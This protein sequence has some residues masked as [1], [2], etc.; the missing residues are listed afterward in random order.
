MMDTPE[1]TSST[2]PAKTAR[3]EKTAKTK[4]PNRRTLRGRIR[5]TI[6]SAS[7][8][9]VMIYMALTL[10]FFAI[11]F[12]PVAGFASSFIGRNVV[13]QMNSRAFLLEHNIDRLEDFDPSTPSGRMWAEKMDRTADLQTYVP[14]HAQS[15]LEE[16]EERHPSRKK[17]PLDMDF[18]AFEVELNGSVIYSNKEKLEQWSRLDAGKL[19]DYYSIPS[20][21]PLINHQGEKVGSVKAMIAPQLV[22][23]IL[24]AVAGMF[25]LLVGITLF[26]THLISKLLSH[27]VLKPLEQLSSRIRAIAQEDYETTINTQIELAR[28]PR[29]IEELAD[30][31]NVIMQKMKEYNERLQSQKETVEEQNEELEAQNEELTESKRK[32]QEAQDRLIVRER[33][34]RNLM[35][36]AGQGFLTF[37]PD[38]LVDQEYSQEC[39]KIF[40]GP[41]GQVDIAGLLALHDPEQ[42]SFLDSLLRKIFSSGEDHRREMYIGLLTDALLIGDRHISVEY[43]M[44]TRSFENQPAMMVILTDITDKVHMENRIESERNTLK[45]VVKVIVEYGDFIDCVR[46]F[47]QFAE[48]DVREIL[49]GPED[50]GSKLLH[51]YRDIHTYKGNFSQFGLPHVTAHLHEAE[52]KLSEAMKLRSGGGEDDQALELARSFRFS[53]WLEEDFAVLHAVLGES[54]FRQQDLLLID[55]SRIVEI[56]KKMMALLAPNECKLL[57]PD[58]RKLR[59]KP[60]KELLKS[61]PDYVETLA[62]RMEKFVHPFTVEG[63]DFLADTE[64]YYDFSRSLIHVFRNIIDHAVEPAEE[65]LALGKDELGTIVCRIEK[66]GSHAILTV[67]DDGRGISPE[68]IRR[69]AAEKGIMTKEELERL[70]DREAVALVFRDEFSTKD[71]VTDISG[72]GIG[73]SAVKA[74]TEKLGG[75]VEIRSVPGQGTVFRFTLPYEDLSG[76]PETDFPAMLQPSVPVTKDYFRTHIGVELSGEEAYAGY[77]ADKLSLM[78][79][80]SFVSLKG[81]VEGAF[82]LSMDRELSRILVRHM[83]LEP[84]TPEEEERFLEDSLA[85]ASNIILGNSFTMF[86]S[87]ADYILMEPPITIRTEGASFKMADTDIWSCGLD[88]G[89][90]GLRLSF[91]LTKR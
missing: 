8:V 9:N 47:N 29:E 55:K 2:K 82:V 66:E 83:V 7:L 36:N 50:A 72:R 51:L 63:D 5:R 49:N 12:R 10:L 68:T 31:T 74:E 54:F 58:L 76:L 23:G 64:R 40:G 38:L 78:E 19:L 57:L 16:A 84:L 28:P 48:S 37:G 39:E 17:P 75:W 41:I 89:Y 71:E 30:S 79:V 61:Y 85:E 81:A 46:D 56:E 20:E 69:L 44:I 27:P 4:R 14:A 1:N 45:M 52:N 25:L 60:F 42:A 33:S 65:R 21:V 91:V 32:L 80:T 77:A 26:I 73:L 90:G 88:S 22:F 6:Y 13:D 59:Y 70:D 86:G 67:T 15:V 53:E 43:K 11:L 34:I 62:E 3:T 18:V 24:V 35:D 87:F